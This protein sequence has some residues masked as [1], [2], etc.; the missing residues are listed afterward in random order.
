M[1]RDGDFRR[2]D[3]G[4]DSVSGWPL[5]DDCAIVVEPALLSSPEPTVPGARQALVIGGSVPLLYP[6]SYLCLSVA[7]HLVWGCYGPVT[8]YLQKV[9]DPSL[10]ASSILC[11]ALLLS[12]LA[13]QV[14]RGA[15]RLYR[16]SKA[17]RCALP[18]WSRPRPS[19]K[20]YVSAA[21]ECGMPLELPGIQRK[22]EGP[23]DVET[24][25]DAVE[26]KGEDPGNLDSSITVRK[27]VIG[28]LY[29]GMMLLRAVTNVTST[30]YALV[31]HTQAV[32]LLNPFITAML[33][34]FVLREKSLPPLFGFAFLGSSLGAF[35]VITGKSWN[36]HLVGAAACGGMGTS[37]GVSSLSTA[38][39][40]GLQI[41]SV[42]LSSMNRVAIKWT[43]RE[44]ISTPMLA[45]FQFGVGFFLVAAAMTFLDPHQW[46]LFFMLDPKSAL[47]LVFFGLVVFYLGTS[48]QMVV[49]RTLGPTLH[50]SF[51]ALRM[52]SA[53]L[54]SFVLMQEPVNSWVSWVGLVLLVGVLC[55]YFRRQLAGKEACNNTTQ[56][57]R[58]TPKE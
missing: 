29:G 13:N 43:Q 28:F 22:D 51:Q 31:Y 5:P 33:S 30:Y 27:C 14:E 2:A 32:A 3:P 7:D 21:A 26:T 46:E 25:G 36:D 39:G 19:R 11:A 55:I 44:R 50:S 23:H 53:L 56:Q 15:V 8:R 47:L 58:K 35:V 6:L 38:T 57:T 18:L 42:V 4:P 1:E 54:G 52:V 40:V 37:C 34:R 41:F 12:S 48:V 10:N 9:T 45:G 16:S 20:Q 24:K 17:R 49:V